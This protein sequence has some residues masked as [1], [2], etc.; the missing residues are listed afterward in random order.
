MEVV[1][2]GLFKIFTIFLG[3]NTFQVSPH[4]VDIFPQNSAIFEFTFTPN[5]DYVFY[6]KSMMVQVYW[7]QIK[8]K[9][10]YVEVPTA[11]KVILT[12]IHCLCF[13]LISKTI[14]KPT[15]FFRKF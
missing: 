2:F 7:K 8:D 10:D 13:L 5:N 14:N 15:N 6:S 3:D 1:P 11:A 4:R 9:L 12:G